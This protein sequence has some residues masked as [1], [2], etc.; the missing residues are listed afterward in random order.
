MSDLHLRGAVAGALVVSGVFLSGAAPAPPSGPTPVLKGDAFVRPEGADDFSPMKAG[1]AL[2]AGSSIRTAP[3]VTTSLK[4]AEGVSIRMAPSTTFTLRATSLLPSEH[5]G[6]TAVH[7]FQV[8][9]SEGEIDL[10][11]HDPGG[12]LGL[13]ALLP[14]GRSVALWRGSG[15]V[16]IHGDDVA[17]ALYEGMGIAGSGAK[18]RPLL[19]NTGVV[20]SPR[21]ISATHATPAAP[22]WV[23]GSSATTPPFAIVRG[24]ERAAV[25]GDW[26]AVPGAVAYRVEVGSDPKMIGPLQI[27]KTDRSTMKTDPVPPGGY[28]VRV[29]AL[30][31]DGLEGPAS[32]P[33]ALR[34]ARLIVPSLAFSA[35][36]GAI[37]LSDNQA[38]R[39][40]DPHD[41]EV[42][43]ASE[44]DPN[45]APRW[46]PATSD[47][48][49]AGSTKRTV[50]IRHDPSHVQTKLLLVSRQ[51]H[52][53]VSFNPPHPR[54]PESPVDV[55]VKVDDP[56]GYLDAAREALQIDVLVDLDKPSLT[57]AHE[58]NTWTARVP[59]H[60]P[61]GPWVVRVSVQD[62]TGVPI[63]AALLDVDGPPQIQKARLSSGDLQVSK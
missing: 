56:S 15:N 6:A 19:P 4:I 21:N 14:G 13:L 25:G 2:A 48:T 38:V 43:T 52:A 32:T 31:A 58:G 55:V 12:A 30:T 3:G 7:A 33:K 59:P 46:V 45:A 22:S 41:I 35:P 1:T 61:P 9:L 42:A 27:S 53:H 50:L 60:A 54:W 26:G 62:R 28:F 24:D 5:P 39:L 37:V 10:E 57:W 29:R 17:V 18:W 11:A 44:F 47:L 20:L 23:D 16:A 51:L 36:G 40:D 34:V 63:G 49:L 8:Q